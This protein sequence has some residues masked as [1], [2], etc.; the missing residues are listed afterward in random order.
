MKCWRLRIATGKAFLAFSIE[1]SDTIIT[2][3]Q[4]TQYQFVTDNESRTE[5]NSCQPWKEKADCFNTL[6][7]SISLDYLHAYSIRVLRNLFFQY[8]CNDAYLVI[9]DNSI[10]L[11][12]CFLPKNEK[13]EVT[14]PSNISS[15][16]Y[17]KSNQLI[18]HLYLR[19]TL[20]DADFIQN[21]YKLS[22]A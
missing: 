21:T 19:W 10:L 14:G 17:I 12:L 18:I 11:L 20:L 4:N 8:A 2:Q 16:V 1:R 13:D 3:R 6:P 5:Y 7:A 15:W 22:F 9:G